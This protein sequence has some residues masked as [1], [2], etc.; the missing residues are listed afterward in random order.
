M[1][2]SD[3]FSIIK[4]G[5]EKLQKIHFLGIILI[6]IL[7]GGLLW[8]TVAF[9]PSINQTE[10]LVIAGPFSFRLSFWDHLYADEMGFFKEYNI[11]VSHVEVRT[12]SEMTQATVAGSIDLMHAVG[13]AIKPALAGASL[14]VV[15]VF[16]RAQFCLIGRPEINSIT[17]IKTYAE[18]AG[19]GSDGDTLSSEYFLRNGMQ[20]G[21]DYSKIF[22]S[23]EAIVPGFLN[24]D[25]DACTA[26]G[27]S[28]TLRQI[29]GKQIVKFAEE[30]P[31][32]CL[33]W[34]CLY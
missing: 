31:Q 23:R 24:K 13:D 34:T 7:I 21:V 32:W 1:L 29:G 28:Y 20:E 18:I 25:F 2:I 26:G 11:N 15:L 19:R 3:N 14:K 17:E 12:A 4:L 6:V 27:N 5:K 33:R 8:Y 22:I 30:F 16:G 9:L 10:N